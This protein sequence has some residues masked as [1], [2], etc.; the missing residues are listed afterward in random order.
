M[1]KV[2]INGLSSISAQDTFKTNF[3][4]S[5]EVIED[6]N[7]LEAKQPSY[8]EYIAP[9]AIRRM[10]KGVKM[11][12]ACAIET[13]KEA[14]IELPDAIITGTGMGCVEDSEKFL[15]NILDNDE[16]FLTPTSFI[17]STHNTVAGQIALTIQCK[18][19]NF[20]YVNGSV[21][22]ESALIDALTQFKQYEI[23]SALIGGVDETSNHTMDLYKLN[24]T[25]KKDEDAPYSIVN[26]QSNGVVFS[27]GANF[28]ALSNTK[29][30][31]SYAELKDVKIY[32][33]LSSEEVY[34]KYQQFLKSNNL[35]ESEV[36]AIV[37]GLNGDVAFDS[38][39]DLLK[40]KTSNIP[41][42]Y[43]KHLSGEFNSASSFGF[44]IAANVL[45]IQQ[46]PDSISLNSIQKSEYKNIVLYNQF[47][48]LDH[49]FV[50]LSK[51]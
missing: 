17:Q 31:S 26:S 45:K 13:L 41:Q 33:K 50:L 16:Q 34:S 42:I 28:C 43:Y 4:E 40:E 47:K 1:D 51:C 44:W 35:E 39:Y 24:G 3:L 8:K 29:S 12:V 20:T 32:N 11:G 49:S 6:K 18:A 48:G 27:E 5:V 46:V 7:V 23:N 30:E 38:I 19:Y 22:F 36:D 25:I 2:F 9:G 21:S 14:N 37:L 15:K 10:A